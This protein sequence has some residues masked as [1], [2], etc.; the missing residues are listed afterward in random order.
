METS[1]KIIVLYKEYQKK[2][3]CDFAVHEK[4]ELDQALGNENRDTIFLI[5]TAYEKNKKL[6]IFLLG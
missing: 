2:V 1:E 6:I 3:H 5:K 4:S